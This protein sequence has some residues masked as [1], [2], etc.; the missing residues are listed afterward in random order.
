[1]KY[2]QLSNLLKSQLIKNQRKFLVGE[3]HKIRE[4]GTENTKNPVRKNL[5]MKY[6]CGICSLKF[7]S[8][9]KLKDHMNDKHESEKNSAEA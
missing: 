7:Q 2:L 4:D 8:K 9:Q 1:M 6:V 3:Q 5:S